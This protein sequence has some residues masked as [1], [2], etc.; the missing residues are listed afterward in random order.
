MFFISSR[1]DE[2]LS[3]LDFKK[4]STNNEGVFNKLL[5]L[6][7]LSKFKFKNEKGGGGILPLVAT[8]CKS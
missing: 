5:F 6:T 2:S 8:T 1:G 7:R 3:K 4:L